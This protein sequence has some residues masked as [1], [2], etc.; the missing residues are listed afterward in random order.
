MLIRDNES[1]FFFIFFCLDNRISGTLKWTIFLGL[2]V[3]DLA[4]DLSG[5]LKLT[6]G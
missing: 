5:V 4:N 3:N 1:G 2:E 6:I